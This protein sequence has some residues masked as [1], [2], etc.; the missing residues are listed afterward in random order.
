M[1]YTLLSIF[2]LSYAFLGAQTTLPTDWDFATTPTTLPTGWTTNTTASYSSGLPDQT[3][4]TSRAGKLQETAHFFTVH[5]FDEPGNVSYNLRA[6]SS[7]GANFSGT[8]TIQESVNGTLWNTLQVH[9]NNAFGDNWTN[10]QASPDPDSRYIR[11]YFANKVSGINVGLDDVTITENTPLNQEINV[12][13]LG[14]DVPNGNAIQFASAMGTPLAIK[15]GIENLGSAGTLTINGSTL[16]GAAASDYSVTTSPS[17]VAPLSSDTLVVTFNA[18]ANGSRSAQLSIANDDA[19]ENPYVIQLDGIGGTGASEPGSNPNALTVEL[20]K[21][22]RLRASYD[23]VGSDGYLVLFKKNAEISASVNDNTNYEIGQGVGNAKVAYIGNATIFWLKEATAQDTFYIQVY[24]FNGE[25]SFINY[26]QS[27]PLE[28]TIITPLSNYRSANYYQGVD[29]AMSSFIDDLHDVINPHITRSYDSYDENMISP[30]ISRDTINNQEA[31]TGVYSGDIVTFSPPFGWGGTGMNREHTLP[32]SWM[33][34]TGSSSTPEYQDYH[35][36]FPT[37]STANGQRS[38]HPLGE[39]VTVSASYGDGKRGTDAFGNT[40]Y[41]PRAAQKGDAAR[42][43]FYM[44]TAYHTVGGNSWALQD[45]LSEGPNQRLDVLLNWHLTDLPSGFERSRNDY[46]DSL[47]QNRNPFIDSAHWACYINFRTMSYIS[48]LDSTCLE[49]TLSGPGTTPT[50]TTD[51]TIG[52]GSIVPEIEWI[53]YPNPVKDEMHVGSL[54][55]DHTSIELFT[56]Q[57]E[58]VFKNDGIQGVETISISELSAGMYIGR[59]S[60]MD[61]EVVTTFRLIKT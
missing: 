7:N 49:A 55:A 3:G 23:D 34:T 31:L 46:L 10:F 58:L 14:A 17:T 44:Q 56:L 15:L 43:I 53:H 51:T 42:A 30:F 12:Q 16:S 35:H 50:D 25:G 45:L 29:E 61:A 22:Y 21:T 11:F 60:T 19:N 41:E 13:Y 18:S 2:L 39:V 8:F 54:N 5:F 40:V 52:V 38:N 59:L 37:I 6:Y 24:A 4:G 27:D 9:T 26:R 20:N 1:R 33:P 47:Q 32:S 36:L 28:E 48:E 57:G